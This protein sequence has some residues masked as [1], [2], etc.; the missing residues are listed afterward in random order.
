[1]QVL[2]ETLL[3]VE[4]VNRPCRYQRAGETGNDK[5]EA[6]KATLER[7]VSQPM[8]LMQPAQSG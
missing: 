6:T 7:F 2:G 3:R 8:P 1:M 5:G 4:R